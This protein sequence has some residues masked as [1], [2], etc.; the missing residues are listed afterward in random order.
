MNDVYYEPKRDHESTVDTVERKDRVVQ[1]MFFVNSLVM[2]FGLSLYS[3]VMRLPLFLAILG[4]VIVSIFAGLTGHNRSKILIL[5]DVLISIIGGFIFE[6]AAV[7]SYP[8]ETLFGYFIF[9]QLVAIIFFISLYFSVRILK[10]L[11]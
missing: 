5:G 6:F 4:I 1:S 7:M 3:T 10:N 9:N 2:I 8:V 11:F